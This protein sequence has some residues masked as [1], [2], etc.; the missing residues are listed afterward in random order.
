MPRTSTAATAQL[1]RLANFVD[2]VT[3]GVSCD[4][5]TRDRRERGRTDRRRRAPAPRR[6]ARV[7]ARR[8]RRARGVDRAARRARRPPMRPGRRRRIRSLARDKQLVTLTTTSVIDDARRARAADLAVQLRDAG[9]RLRGRA[10][11]RR[12]VRPVLS[13]RAA[14]RRAESRRRHPVEARLARICSRAVALELAV[15]P[16]GGSFGPEHRY[17]GLGALPPLF[18]GLAFHAIP[19]TSVTIGGAIPRAAQLDD[20][21]GAAAH[22]VRAVRRVHA[23][24]ERSR[25]P[26]DQ[27]VTR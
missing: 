18:V 3:T 8:F 21:R 12:V 19:Y 25:P 24:A 26:S 13:R 1:R 27:A 16:Y 4:T 22:D 11:A 15:A 6:V 17:G 7:P 5:P 2:L 23:P 10:A 9:R 20:P 14:P